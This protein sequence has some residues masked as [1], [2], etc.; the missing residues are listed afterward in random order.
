MVPGNAGYLANGGSLALAE[1]LLWVAGCCIGNFPMA[2][3]SDRN[4]TASL[5]AAFGRASPWL[6]ATL[7]GRLALDHVCQNVPAPCSTVT[8]DP[9]LSRFRFTVRHGS[10]HRFH[11]G[12]RGQPADSNPDTARIQAALDSCHPGG[13]VKLI[14]AGSTMRFWQAP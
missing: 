1:F 10:G 2:A 14:A 13:V 8:A 12:R 6:A 4:N 5:A 7:D 11:C 3:G 9:A